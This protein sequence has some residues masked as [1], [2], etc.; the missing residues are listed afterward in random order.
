MTGVPLFIMLSGALLLPKKEPNRD[1]FRKRLQRIIR[2]WITWTCLAFLLIKQPTLWSVATILHGLLAI[3]SGSF[4][5]IPVI[6]CLYMLIPLFRL[7]VQGGKQSYAWYFVVLWFLATSVLP[8]VRNT[9][10]FPLVVDNGLVTQTVHYSGYL[11]LGWLLSI[12]RPTKKDVLL[13]CGICAIFF[14]WTVGTNGLTSHV[15]NL[16]SS[17][18]SPLI[19]CIA[20][21]LFILIRQAESWLQNL[22]DKAKQALYTISSLT[23]GVFFLHGLVVTKVSVL[24]PS[25]FPLF[26]QGILLWFLVT[27]VSFFLIFLMS[28]IVKLKTWVT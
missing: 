2:P 23:F 9:M 25:Q 26:S 5:F 12:L 21:A 13:L 8:S 11:L 4:T 27:V 28:R 14:L 3:F 15:T 20:A 19:I 17:Y 24:I 1:F 18:S 6:F 7:I 10:A 22:P 16:N